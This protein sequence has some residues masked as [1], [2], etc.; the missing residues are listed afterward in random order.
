MSSSL[1]LREE[2]LN[3]FVGA[4]KMSGAV[5]NAFMKDLQTKAD[6]TQDRSLFLDSDFFPG[7]NRCLNCRTHDIQCDMMEQEGTHCTE[8][9]SDGVICKK[10][11]F[12]YQFGLYSL[13][14]Y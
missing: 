3:E 13:F 9:R 14:N 12:V 7:A 11:R 5:V 2:N 6:K 1:G 4:N 8:C 10:P